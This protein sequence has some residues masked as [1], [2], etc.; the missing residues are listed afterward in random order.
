MA[1]YAVLGATG[2]TGGSI[3][4]VLLKSADKK[5]RP[6][7]RSKEKLLTQRPELES[8]PNVTIFEGQLQNVETLADCLTGTTAAFL[9]IGETDNVPGTSVAQEQAKAAVAAL[10]LIR[11]QDPN[12]RLPQLIVLSSASLE[13]KLMQD[14]PAAAYAVL[15][16]AA[17]HV[18]DDLR[19]AEE[20]LR[21][22]E[23]IKQVYIKPGGLV[24]DIPKGHIL[25]TERQQTFLSFLDLAA[26]MVEVAEAD[27]DTWDLKNVSVI[28]AAP[29]TRFEWFVP[30]F[31]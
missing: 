19:L 11:E 25:S 18:Y 1:T 9:A 31:L 13:R 17:G 4:E 27:D 10:E 23:W 24:H 30:Y 12:A 28:P 16:R 6:F 15:E 22:H 2:S 14:F 8:L 3:V 26:G 7:V 21:S 5:I 29:G 20:Y